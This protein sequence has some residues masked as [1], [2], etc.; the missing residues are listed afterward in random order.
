VQLARTEGL[1]REQNRVGRD[2]TIDRLLQD[3][4]DL[5]ETNDYVRYITAIQD[6]LLAETA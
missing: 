3:A 2:A 6:L 5:A 1:V 4:L